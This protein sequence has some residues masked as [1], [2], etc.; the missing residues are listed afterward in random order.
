LFSDVERV[1]APP[2]VV[3]PPITVVDNL[4]SDSSIYALSANMGRVLHEEV[5]M[6]RIRKF[7]SNNQHH[8][9]SIVIKNNNLHKVGASFGN[10]YRF[11][12]A[13]DSHNGLP[14][15]GSFDRDAL[16]REIGS[17]GPMSLSDDDVRRLSLREGIVYTLMPR[18]SPPW[19]AV[20]EVIAGESELEKLLHGANRY[21]IVERHIQL[22]LGHLL[23]RIVQKFGIAPTQIKISTVGQV[24]RQLYVRA[25]V[26]HVMGNARM[27]EFNFIHSNDPRRY[28]VH[29]VVAS[30][31]WGMTMGF[32]GFLVNENYPLGNR[33][34]TL[35]PYNNNPVDF[36]IEF[37]LPA[38]TE[39]S[40]GFQS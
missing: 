13:N 12:V 11:I 28:T 24:N 18:F 23:N 26:R 31:S 5:Q 8:Q 39:L 20:L 35:I 2:P 22:N 40:G 7:D 17:T 4:E 36:A 29:N 14:G 37:T 1:P 30:A 21:N 3:V 9:N 19:R 33:I 15:G 10:Q 25:G 27:L 38:Q 34:E 16:M 6:T 32:L